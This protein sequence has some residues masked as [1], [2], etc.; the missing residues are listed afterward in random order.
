M[1]R[2]PLIRTTIDSEHDHGKGENHGYWT[3][4]GF[5]A[6]GPGACNTYVAAS[7]LVG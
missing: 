1:R 3:T 2:A 5:D 6:G 4:A 7:S